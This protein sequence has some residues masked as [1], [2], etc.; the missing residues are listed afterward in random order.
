MMASIATALTPPKLAKE[1]ACKPEKIITFINSG[2]LRA[3][4]VSL[5]P[6]TGRPRWR[7]TP[8]AI[9]EFEVRRSAVK[10]AAKRRRKKQSIGVL[11]IIK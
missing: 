4:D 1:W 11:D 7:I 9:A 2:E 8:E 5:N 3:F 10:P 6:G